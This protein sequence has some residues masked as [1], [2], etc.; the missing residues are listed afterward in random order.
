MT[1]RL[2]QHAREECARRGIAPADVEAVLAA[3]GQIVPGLGSK[4]V[5]QS[6]QTCEGRPI[7]LRGVV[8]RDVS[9]PLVVTVY[10]TSKIAKY[11]SPS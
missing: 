1:A 10:R 2:S 9:P 3:P 5:S 8:A 6:V 7:L 11:W 4:V